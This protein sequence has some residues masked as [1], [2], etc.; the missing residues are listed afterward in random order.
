MSVH[1]DDLLPDLR[2]STDPLDR[3]LARLLG[4]LAARRPATPPPNE[5][6]A[7][8]LA[9]ASTASAPLDPSTGTNTMPVPSTV[10]HVVQLGR[11]APRSSPMRP[12]LVPL[13]KVLK[14]GLLAKVMLGTTVAL[15]G[16]GAAAATGNL[17]GTGDDNVVV[18]TPSDDTGGSTTPSDDPLG[19]IDLDDQDEDDD[20]DDDDG[21]GDDGPGDDDQG[22]DADDQ[23]EDEPGDDDGDNSG[24]GGDDQGED[25]DDDQGEDDDEPGDDDGDNSGPGGDD[26]NDDDDSDDDGDSDEDGDNSGPG[27]GDDSDDDSGEDDESGDD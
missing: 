26:S 22:E 5:R 27:D 24:P 12:R 13:K 15:T 17:P 1:D 20:A 25:D 2:R 10:D 9:E 8:F 19:V 4:R 23:G 11:P 21:P 3:R 7:A 14:T 16:V 6:L 18:V